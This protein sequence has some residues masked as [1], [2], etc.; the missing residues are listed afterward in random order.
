LS[1]RK[2]KICLVRRYDFKWE[3]ASEEDEAKLM[4]F[5][6]GEVV[7][8]KYTA[9]RSYLNL[10]RY[11]VM[12]EIGFRSQTQYKDNDIY[13]KAVEMEADFFEEVT[14]Y[15]KGE[16]LKRRWPKSIAYEKLDEAEFI[17][18]KQRVGDVICENL[19]LDQKELNEEVIRLAYSHS[20]VRK[21]KANELQTVIPDEPREA[22]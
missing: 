14:L 7:E 17:D 19:E 18:L 22:K 8:F 15:F 16:T 5:G 4:R 11:F 3:G 21:E 13:R 12:L 6:V 20:E 9:I 10:Q 1:S 2:N